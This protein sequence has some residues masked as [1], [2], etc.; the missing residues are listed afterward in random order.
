M[1]PNGAS[2]NP[3]KFIP[4]N[5]ANASNTDSLIL[6]NPLPENLIGKGLGLW[7][8]EHEFKNGVFVR[9]RLYCYEDAI[10]IQP[11]IFAKARVE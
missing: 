5:L 4:G 3:L 2:I 6:R 10:I 11:L 9:P 8:L 7:K 1:R